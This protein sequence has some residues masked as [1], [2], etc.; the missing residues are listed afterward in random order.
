M[1]IKGKQQHM[2]PRSAL[3]Y[4][5]MIILGVV[6][7]AVAVPQL[8]KGQ[9]E[10]EVEP[11]TETEYEIVAQDGSDDEFTYQ[12]SELSTGA[13]SAVE[14]AIRADNGAART[15]Q[16]VPEFRYGDSAEQYYISYDGD[17]YLLQTSGASQFGNLPTIIMRFVAVCGVVVIVVSG[18]DLWRHRWSR[19]VA[20]GE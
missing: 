16:R 18:F 6:L 19:D 4:V 10:Y 12:Y 15:D 8:T 3:P 1:S 9:Y 20:S 13:Q 11:V 14:A 17:Y 7:V 5:A 2:V